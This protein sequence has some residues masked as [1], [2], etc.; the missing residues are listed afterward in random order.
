MR[1]PL[2]AV[3]LV[4][5]LA[6]TAGCAG[7][8]F[9]PH[10]G[11]VLTPERIGL[12]YED[13]YFESRDG[14][15]LHAWF[16]PAQGEAVATVLHLHGNAENISTHIGSVYWM[17]ARGFNV[18]L[19][20]YR[21][22][23]LSLGSPSVEGALEDVDSAMQALLAR[24]DVDRSRIVVFGQSLGGALAIHYVAH[25]PYRQFVRALIVES[26][27]SSYREIAREKLAAFWLT[28]PL[29]YPL[30]WTVSDDYSPLRAVGQ[31]SPIPLLIL[32]GDK[33]PIVPLH[34][35]QRLYEAAHEP[36]ALWVVP[37]G[38]HTEAMRH[39]ALR[40]RLAAYIRNAVG[41]GGP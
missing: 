11:H 28:W 30:S 37:G 36:K 27:F 17:P 31:I 12:N 7:M 4:L 2:R 10:R 9:L 34:H 14:V 24:G 18:F 5:L 22:Y 41:A 40:D 39:D 6:A 16:L 32:H 3:V 20:D 35:G 19:L 1:R 8:F 23:G 38:G 33:D 29:Q 13:V 26:A 21:G 25:S 15:R